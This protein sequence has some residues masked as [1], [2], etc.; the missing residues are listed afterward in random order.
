MF[1]PFFD[2]SSLSDKELYDKITEVSLRIS[3][4]RSAG[5]QYEMIQ[6]MFTVIQ[7]CEFEIQNRQAH[8][9]LEQAAK[10][11]NCIFDSDSYLNDKDDKKHESTRK[12]NYKRGW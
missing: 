2:P 5:I 12:Q 1:H 4:A 8:K 7:A 3:A 10:E 11:D 6:S 9:D